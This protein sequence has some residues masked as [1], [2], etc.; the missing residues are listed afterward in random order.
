MEGF[1]SLMGSILVLQ[2]D[3]ICCGQMRLWMSIGTVFLQRLMV[4]VGRQSISCRY[5]RRRGGWGHVQVELWLF[6]KFQEEFGND[7]G[8]VE[9]CATPSVN[10]PP[11]LR[12]R[13]LPLTDEPQISAPKDPE[14]S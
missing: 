14:N 10:V 6:R 7:D 13:Q 12:P 9:R 8:L 2:L 3:D 1:N 11:V 4:S 5:I